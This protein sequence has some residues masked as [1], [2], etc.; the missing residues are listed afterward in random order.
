MNIARS[1]ILIGVNIVL[2]LTILSYTH[3]W[4]SAQ[5]QNISSSDTNDIRMV[6]NVKDNTLTLVNNTSNE[7]I[8]VRNI[9]A[10]AGNMISAN[11]ENTKDNESLSASNLTDVKNSTAIVNM[12][13]KFK[14]LQN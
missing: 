4:I 3:N 14:E 10:N 5:S 2:S 1:A 12:T 7:T 13:E 11:T 9:T 8:S 6:Y